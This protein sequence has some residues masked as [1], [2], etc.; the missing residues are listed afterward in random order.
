MIV[1]LV[2]G[3]GGCCDDN[4]G[5]DYS[6]VEVEVEADD[7]TDDVIELVINFRIHVEGVVGADSIVVSVIVS[8]WLSQYPFAKLISSFG[9]YEL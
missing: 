6:K 5:E 1:Y 9:T 8:L 3:C 2:Y 7:D 4:D